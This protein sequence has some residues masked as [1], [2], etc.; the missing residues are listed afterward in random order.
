M[1]KVFRDRDVDA[2][3]TQGQHPQLKKREG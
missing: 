1:P 2:A 3:I